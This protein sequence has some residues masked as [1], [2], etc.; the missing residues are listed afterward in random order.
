MTGAVVAQHHLGSA[1]ALQLVQAAIVEAER[2]GLRIAAVA[3]DAAGL[4]L[5]ALRMD[6]VNEAFMTAATDKAWT[7]VAFRR[8]TDALR[9]R[10]ADD[11]L[12]AGA[13]SRSRMLLWGGG[14]PVLVGGACV[15]AIGVSGGLV[16]QDIACAEAALAA[17]CLA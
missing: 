10:M 7:A 1:T 12:R 15:G 8:S 13:A 3:V 6:G 16:A 14:L 4:P 17:C 5:A 2:Q 9:E 11:E